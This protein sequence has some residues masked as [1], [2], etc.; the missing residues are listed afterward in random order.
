MRQKVAKKTDWKE[1]E[2][3]KRKDGKRGGTGSSV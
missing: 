1:R 2:K 3:E